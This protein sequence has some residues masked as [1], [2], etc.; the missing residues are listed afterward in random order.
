MYGNRLNGESQQ[1]LSVQ[2]LGVAIFLVDKEWDP[3]LNLGV[4]TRQNSA[5]GLDICVFLLR[6][7]VLQSLILNMAMLKEPFRRRA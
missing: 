7:H 6:V 3:P 2:L 5:D 4:K 1:G